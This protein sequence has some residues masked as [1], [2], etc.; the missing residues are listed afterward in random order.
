MNLAA[1]IGTMAKRGAPLPYDAEVEY[2]E[3]TGTQ[4]I[5]I[6]VECSIDSAFE[7][8]CA[9]TVTTEQ[10]I[11]LIGSTANNRFHI[12][13]FSNGYTRG[14]IS[15]IQKPI[16]SSDTD[17]HRITLDARNKSASVDETNVS[18]NY[19]QGDFP[20]GLGFWI[21]GRYSPNSSYQR[22]GFFKI[23]SFMFYDEGISIRGFI[24][25]RF[26]NEN[27]EREGAMYDRAGSGGMNPDGTPRTDGLYRNR[28]TGSFGWQDK[29]GVYVPPT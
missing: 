17:F 14:C 24:P 29:N 11:G 4:Y 1:R 10:F 26:T 16:V 12:S 28:G 27:G 6:N 5:D 25:V 7:I 13:L 3:S 9:P 15:V 8:I 2:L 19:T 20:S 18:I 21:F 22:K 23:K